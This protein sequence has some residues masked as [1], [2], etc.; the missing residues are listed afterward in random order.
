MYSRVDILKAIKKGEIKIIPF[1]QKNLQPNSYKLHLDN[2]I[3]IAK[4]GRID[5]QKIIDYSKFYLK[6]KI[7]TFVLK[8]KMFILARS[9][10]K[11]SLSKKQGA[12]VNGRTTLARVGMSITQTAPIIHSGHGI[13]KPRKIIFEISNE[14]P[15]DIILKDGMTI[16]EISFYKLNTPTDRLYDSFGKYGTRKN[17]DELLPLKEV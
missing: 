2:E 11:I 9:K 15:F 1:H 4:K 13:P 17:K 16:S 5:I 10:E 7:K 8:P 6:K 3:A 12:M 14:G